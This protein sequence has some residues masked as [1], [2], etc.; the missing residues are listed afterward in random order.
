MSLQHPIEID[1]AVYSLDVIKSV[2]YR[3][4][5]DCT[6]ELALKGGMAECVLRA[7]KEKSDADWETIASDFW[8]ELAD[9]DL[10]RSIAEETSDIRNVILAL[11]FSKTG[12]QSDE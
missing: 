10:R 3:L 4:P 2:I 5:Q 8:R 1:L 6:A 12:L 7:S 9:Q 11:A